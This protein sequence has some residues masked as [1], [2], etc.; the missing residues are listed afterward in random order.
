[1]SE[2]VANYQG[3]TERLV[4]TTQRRV[5]AVWAA[6]DAGQITGA[7]A[8]QLI[9]AIVNHSNASAVGMADRF[10]AD[11]IEAAAG[12]PVPALGHPPAD[13]LDRLHDAVATVLKAAPAWQPGD[14]DSP[15]MR[16]HRLARSEPLHAG[17]RSAETAMRSHD[18]VK[19]WRR[20][21][22]GDACQLCQWW[23]R[24]GR[25]WPDAHPFQSHQ[26]CNCQPEAVM[27]ERIASTGYTRRLEHALAP[28]GTQFDDRRTR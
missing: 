2:I 6:F 4:S 11:Q 26:G 3:H 28:T 18:A 17:H 9:A 22:D 23:S 20:S 16:L 7:E 27:A 5:A 24:D 8:Q 14:T 13:D 25:I 10:I 21:M 15:S 1:M 12:V 19:G